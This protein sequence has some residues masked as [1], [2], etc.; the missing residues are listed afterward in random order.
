LFHLKNFD[1]A[2]NLQMQEAN[3]NLKLSIQAPKMPHTPQVKVL[4]P[5]KPNFSSKTILKERTPGPDS[6]NDRE[7]TNMDKQSSPI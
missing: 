6:F 7:E 4:S 2:T 3:E 1:K 5:L